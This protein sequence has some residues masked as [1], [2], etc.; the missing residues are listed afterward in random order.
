M[1]AGLSALTG[2]ADLALT[3]GKKPPTT[4]GG[5]F[6]LAAAKKTSQDFETFFASQVLD[7]MFAD[8]KTDGMFGG[9]HGEEMFRSLLLDQY[10]KQIGKA[11]SFG[12]G[13]QVLKSM[14]AQQEVAS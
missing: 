5:S 10:A 11:G 7:Q 2:N 13:D 6:N 9:G 4:I 12:I 1:D 3:G 8:V 14:I